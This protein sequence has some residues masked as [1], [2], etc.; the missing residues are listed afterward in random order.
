MNT[1]SP[2]YWWVQQAQSLASQLQPPKWL[3]QEAQQRAVL[4][5]NHV[6]MQEPE[7]C[8]RLR[9]VAGQKVQVRWRQFSFQVVFTPA[10]LVDIGDPLQSA[11]LVLQV[12]ETSPW[13]LAQSLVNG[14]K[15]PI[16]I[17][18][19]VQ[20]AAEINWLIDHVRWDLE[21]DLARLIG[22]APAHAI[23]QVMRQLAQALRQWLVRPGTKAPTQTGG[24]AGWV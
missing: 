15:P 10:G 3:I 18:G 7:A 16:H 8:Q 12:A 21:E 6:L 1:Q 20:L 24:Q 22:D 14:Q 11:H 13:V 17:E 9:R 2:F 4:L 19:D 23:G 5:I